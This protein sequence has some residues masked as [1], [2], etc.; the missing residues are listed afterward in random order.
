MSAA[1]ASTYVYLGIILGVMGGVICMI[2]PPRNKILDVIC[3]LSGG[4]IGT[5]TSISLIGNQLNKF[6]LITIIAFGYVG[7]SITTHLVGGVER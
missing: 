4:V 3:I 5:L 1:T 6:S 7:A 2:F